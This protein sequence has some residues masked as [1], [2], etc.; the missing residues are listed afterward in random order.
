[1]VNALRVRT[2][3]Q[4]Q[5]IPSPA[6]VLILDE[7][8]FCCPDHCNIRLVDILMRFIIHQQQTGIVLHV[9]TQNN[10][11]ARELC[12]LNAWQKIG[13]LQGLTEPSR[14]AVT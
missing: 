10:D 7:F 9:V 6:S 11:V 5:P 1:L 4:G 14:N 3:Q 12:A 13:P 2:N 8:N